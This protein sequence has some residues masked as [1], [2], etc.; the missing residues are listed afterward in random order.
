MSQNDVLKEF[1]EREYEYGFVVDFAADEAPR[2]LSEDINL[3]EA[4]TAL[5]GRLYD[6]EFC[7]DHSANAAEGGRCTHEGNCS[8]RPVLVNLDRLVHDALGKLSLKSLVRSEPAMHAWLKVRLP[9]E[10]PS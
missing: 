9:S 1:T 6:M 8:L 3:S 7:D 5:G 2:G 4:L 10:S